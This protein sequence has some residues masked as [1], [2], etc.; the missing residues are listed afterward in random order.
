[1]T[2]LQ[3]LK[4]LIEAVYR[5]AI[6]KKIIRAVYGV[7][8]SFLQR[9]YPLYNTTV[10]L[11]LTLRCQC[12][13]EHC[14]VA[15]L[16]AAPGSEFT[17]GEISALIRELAQLRVGRVYF[18]GGEPLL[19]PGIKDHISLAKSFGLK[20]ILDTNGMLVN[21]DMAAS[22]K[23]CGLD[24]LRVS[25]DSPV[26]E[27]HDR[28]RGAKGLFNKVMAA[29]A[30]CK[31][32][33]LECHISVCATEEN[34]K[35]GRIAELIELAGRLEVKVRLLSP[36][37]CGRLYNAEGSELT[38]EGIG[39]LKRLLSPG[40]VYWEYDRGDRPDYDFL[41]AC[42]RRW[43]FYISP[44][45]DVQPCCY[46]P[47]IFG[48]IRR[49]SLTAITGRM[50]KTALFKPAK[51]C[52]CPTNSAG[53]R[54]M[55]GRQLAVSGGRPVS[56]EAQSSPNHLAEWDEW[57][58]SY[59]ATIDQ[60]A[61]IQDDELLAAVDFR[62]KRVLDLGCG[63]GRFARRL[64]CVAA[65]VTAVDFSPKM[66][67]KARENLQGAENVDFRLVD[68][69]AMKTPWGEYDIITAL[70]VMHH[71]CDF[72]AT[73]KNMKASLA[74]GGKIILMD[75][76][77]TATVRDTLK[78]YLAGAARVGWLNFAALFLTNA[79]PASSSA[80][81]RL[82]ET[83]FTLQDF[84]NRYAALL[85]GAETGFK[86]GVFAYLEWTKPVSPPDLSPVTLS[87]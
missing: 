48:N 72:A 21:T 2:I 73:V 18:F 66:L 26:E 40:R 28:F 76:L 3:V 60:L 35:N 43:M 9:K 62:G 84:R 64:S 41:C 42:T 38:P 83:R 82:T 6:G 77:L 65:K 13:C 33:G 32:C 87:A 12:K 5:R 23:Q 71:V 34:L 59:G 50:W 29:I 44:A 4:P 79:A 55:F 37:R 31:A 30:A 17:H 52:D 16:Q 22:L 69:E 75:R 56:Y 85:P 80:R 36:I 68:M 1:M 67:E 45:G 20:C 58:A 46:M 78:F 11:A 14:G 51:A 86:G 70:S 53:F 19:V 81:H 54:E 39:A 8:A 10:M 49:E 47:V 27:E 15:D 63:T 7:Y 57:A 25:L 24:M 74:P 61:G